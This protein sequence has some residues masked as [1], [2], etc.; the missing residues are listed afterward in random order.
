MVAAIRGLS[1][2]NFGRWA[3]ND[4]LSARPD[5]HPG[6]V[7]LRRKLTKRELDVLNELRRGRTNKE[8]A[9]RLHVSITTVN[10][11]VQQILKKLRVRTRTQAVAMVNDEI[12]WRPMAV[13]DSGG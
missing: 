8:I 2:P 11:H 7:S 4:L 5:G 9:A 6:Y 10:K 3:F 13:G 1:S 12:T